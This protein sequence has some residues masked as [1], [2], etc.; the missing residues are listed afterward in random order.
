MAGASK[1]TMQPRGPSCTGSLPP[2]PNRCS[3]TARV[4]CH[5]SRSR[6]SFGRGRLRVECRKLGG[7]GRPNLFRSGLI[8]GR[9]IEF[10]QGVLN[11][12]TNA[13]SMCGRDRKGL[14]QPERPEIGN[15]LLP[16][17]A[18]GLVDRKQYPRGRTAQL[19]GDIAVACRHAAA[20]VDHEDHKISLDHCL[21]RLSGHLRGNAVT[22]NR[23]K[24]AS[25]DHDKTS[26]TISP[27]AI[28]TIAGQARNVVNQGISTAG[29]PVEERRLADVWS[30]DDRNDRRWNPTLRHSTRNA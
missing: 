15:R 3:A 30:T 26:V 20:P 21:A 17:H 23:L 9:L 11:Q 10:G 14:P 4:G 5:S 28:M 2:P 1:P 16:R 13:I 27:L 8:G 24:A 19:I 29:E 25:V 22:C 18:L 12:F 7:S 6:A